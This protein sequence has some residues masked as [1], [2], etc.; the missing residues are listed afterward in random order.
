LQLPGREHD[1]VASHNI[2]YGRS[3]IGSA[4]IQQGPEGETSI[5]IGKADNVSEAEQIG[6]P[7]ANHYQLMI[8]HF[9][10]AVLNDSELNYHLEESMG[11]MRVLEAQIEA[12]RMGQRA[13]V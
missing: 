11:N 3:Y 13:T 6:I 4:P 10:D 12:V 7:R 1:A 2:G 8:E 5:F 9:A